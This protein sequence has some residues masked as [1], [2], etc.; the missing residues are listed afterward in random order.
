MVATCIQKS[1]RRFQFRCKLYRMVELY[2]VV[3][4]ARSKVEDNVTKRVVHRSSDLRLETEPLFKA[5]ESIESRYL[6]PR[7]NST[8]VLKTKL[9]S[10]AVTLCAATLKAKLHRIRFN[11]VKKAAI[12]FQASWKGVSHRKKMDSKLWGRCHNA[13]LGVRAELEKFNGM[14]RRR[15]ASFDREEKGVYIPNIGQLKGV[16]KL[17]VK[18]HQERVYFAAEV[19]KINKR[20]KEQA[21]TVMITNELFFNLDPKSAK[22]KRRIAITELTSVSVS[23]MPDNF[24]IIHCKDYDYIM[25]CEQK[26]ELVKVLRDRYWYLKHEEL[27][28]NFADKL[29]AK[30]K[31]SKVQKF[32]FRRSAEKK[33]TSWALDKADKYLMIVDVHDDSTHDQYASQ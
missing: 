23:T 10:L 11:K 31:S 33:G 12:V 22:E 3:K 13:M 18:H 28:V 21:R 14:K 30:N 19:K 32:E 26:I 7:S 8:E 17:I 9:K 24:F 20:W 5:W 4:K 27:K 2:A 25:V 16:T 6:K 29:E 15:K 1:I